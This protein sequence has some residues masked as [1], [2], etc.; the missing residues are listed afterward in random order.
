MS[1]FGINEPY[2][3][4]ENVSNEVSQEIAQ[5]LALLNEIEE[6]IACV[7]GTHKVHPS[8]KLYRLCVHLCA[9]LAES[10]YG[11]MTAGG[12][13]IMKAANTGAFSVSGTSIGLQGSFL[14]DEK[15]P[16]TLFTHQME[17][18]YLFVR[19]F[20][21]Q[22]KSKFFLFFPGA[23]GTYHELF[24]YANLINKE[25]LEPRPIICVGKEYWGGLIDWIES[26]AVQKKFL[27]TEALAGI[28][29]V[30][31]V[32]EIFEILE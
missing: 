29:I 6:P 21:R 19:D 5:G 10:G 27:S 23:F 1:D 14:S 7:F 4:P 3:S 9:R 32:E 16:S 22:V 25:I 31:S 17:F 15:P 8:D 20:L 12:G 11:I 24:E 28:Q 2:L 13:G 30:D 18:K 26:Q